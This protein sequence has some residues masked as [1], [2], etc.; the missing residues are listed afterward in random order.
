MASI[1]ED[2]IALSLAARAP[3]A[4]TEQATSYFRALGANGLYILLH[5]SAI[6]TGNLTFRIYSREIFEGTDYQINLDHATPITATGRYAHPLAL[7]V[8]RQPAGEAAVTVATAVKQTISLPAPD[9]FRF[10]VLH[11]DA[12]AWTYG[13]SFKRVR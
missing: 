10:G 2:V 5:V 13:V 4:A 3:G 8:A 9:I 12:S 7:G 11:S 6:G 1:Y